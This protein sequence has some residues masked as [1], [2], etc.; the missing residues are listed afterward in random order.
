MWVLHGDENAT[1]QALLAREGALQPCNPP[2]PSA[3]CECEWREKVHLNI[4]KEAKKYLQN[5]KAL[6]LGFVSCVVLA[7]GIFYKDTLFWK[8]EIILS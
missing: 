7:K 6:Q 8:T 5:F 2:G 1:C 4:Y 3:S